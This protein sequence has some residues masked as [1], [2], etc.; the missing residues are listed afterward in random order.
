MS[1]NVGVYCCVLLNT[2]FPITYELSPFFPL[3][4]RSLNNCLLVF[5][6]F[7]ICAKRLY[8][9]L[10]MFRVVTCF[11]LALCVCVLYALCSRHCVSCLVLVWLA[12]ITVLSVSASVL[13]CICCRP[14]HVVSV[15]IHTYVHQNSC[16][17]D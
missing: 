12:W 5:L 17:I 11:T 16:V 1:L 3:V 14:K 10:Q 7:D 8:W 4:L 6:Y 15:S 9:Y 13:I 2:L